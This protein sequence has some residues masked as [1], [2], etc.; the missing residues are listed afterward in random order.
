M[1]VSRFRPTSARQKAFKKQW[2]CRRHR[3]LLHFIIILNNWLTDCRVCNSWLFRLQNPWKNID[4]VDSIGI[5]YE[6]VMRVSRPRPTSARQK[7]YK[8]QWFWWRHRVLLHFI[9]ILNNWLT[10]WLTDCRVC[11]SSLF[12]LQSPWENVDFVDCIMFQARFGNLLPLAGCR[13]WK[14]AG[15]INWVDWTEQRDWGCRNLCILS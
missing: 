15:V 10:D 5:N 2:F 6:D 9:I 11:N 8:K 4:F 7:A 12:R 1:R 14:A 13:R 3:V